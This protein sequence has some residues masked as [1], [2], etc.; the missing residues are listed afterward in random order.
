MSDA[1]V[2]QLLAVLANLLGL[3]WLALAM[4]AHW[5]QVRGTDALKARTVVLLRSLGTLSIGAA[6]VLCL[7]ADHPSMA[8]LVWVMSLAGSALVVAFSLAW[9]PRLLSPLVAWAQPS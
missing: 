4:E 5:E 9:R 6:L 3:A 2:L 7:V 1:G 8:V